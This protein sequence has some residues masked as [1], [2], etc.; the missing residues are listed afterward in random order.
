MAMAKHSEIRE[1]IESEIRRG[2]Y[3]VGA[4]LPT[5]QELMEQFTVSRNP[6]QKAMNALVETGMVTRKRGAGTIVASAGLR[7]NLLR[8]T[9]PT[10]TGPE[11]HGEHRVIDL[12]VASAEN[13]GLSRNAFSPGTPTAHLTRLKIS[14]EGKPLALER[15]AID[16]LLAPNA[17]SQDLASLTTIAYY[18]SIKLGIRR[19]NTSI[20]AVH[21]NEQDA[22]HMELSSSTP[23]IRQHR[24]VNLNTEAV[25]EVA[26]FLIHPHNMTLEVSQIDNS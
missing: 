19:A 14:A 6:V 4:K 22:E 26:E 12:T 5:E 2:T 8:L 3:E 9:D 18:N 21:L 24:T 15:C 25:V 17:L 13:F 10:L 1:W 11:V 20:S 23:V 7:S 16:L